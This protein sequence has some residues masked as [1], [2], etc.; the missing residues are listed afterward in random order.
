[1]PRSR[2]LLAFLFCTF[3]IAIPCGAQ[4]AG[5]DSSTRS[6]Y[7]Q[8]SVRLNEDQTALETIKVDLKRFTG[9]T[10]ATTFTRSNGEFEFT[11]LGPGQYYIVI[12]E[13]GFEPVHELVELLNGP[14]TGYYV[15][16]RKPLEVSEGRP[17]SGPSIS[18]HELSLPS[19]ARD[20][21]QHG[22][23]RLYEKQDVKGSLAFFQRAVAVVPAYYEAY[24]QMGIAY[25]KINDM[26]QAESAFRKAV[27][28]SDKK[29][30]DALFALGAILCNKQ[31]FEEAEPL[32][33]R[34]LEL[35]AN[36]WR[37]H[38]E[39][40]RAEYGRKNLDVAEKDALEARTRKTGDPQ[41]HLLLANI[42]IQ[43]R[44]YAALLEDLDAYLK[45]APTG[46]M[47]D[48]ARQTRDKVQAALAKAQ[49]APPPAPP[50]P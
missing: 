41:V 49:N 11:N 15:F 38:F 2:V 19:K 5:S 34:G 28:V 4:R 42:H 39:L 29:Y 6:F 17:F 24:Y 44:N 45:L 18:A 25:T 30:P 37:G 22:L 46:P 50:K 40:A 47:A 12:E 1:M 20:A 10:V 9:E 36:S 3:L 27:E 16:L 43:K 8:G 7:L 33:R 48:Q 31:A 14:R 26:D 35:D 21:M 13:K 32:L 23:E